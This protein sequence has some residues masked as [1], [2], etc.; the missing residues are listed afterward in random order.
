MKNTVAA[1]TLAA[2]MAASGA[3]LAQPAT[4]RPAHG[5][6]SL[7]SDDRAALL[8]ARVA[9]IKAALRLTPEQEKLWPGFEKALRD[10]RAARAE[11]MAGMRAERREAREERKEAREEG[12]KRDFVE[13]LRKGADRT[14][15]HARMATE[16]ATE[17]RKFADAIE[18]LYN[19]LD[20]G[21]KR[22]LRAL[23][24][25]DGFGPKQDGH[26]HHGKHHDRRR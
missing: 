11:R 1:L 5:R 2:V 19:T 23:L 26:D 6:H 13:A 16:R 10:S 15:E 25:K 12:R 4:E 9:G 8:D 14:A 24:R 18:P 20:D 21:Q 7:N 3:A 22:R 17:M